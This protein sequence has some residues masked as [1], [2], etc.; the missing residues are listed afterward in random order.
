MYPTSIDGK[1]LAGGFRML[2]QTVRV[3]R[4]G[5]SRSDR[6]FEEA[7]RPCRLFAHMLTPEFQVRHRWSPN[8]VAFWDNRSTLHYAAHDF[9]QAH[10][11]MHRVT[12]KGDV[13]LGPDQL[14]GT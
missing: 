10:R 1:P 6:E 3:F 12:L 5:F 14:K 13:P 7:L 11:L 2:P 8:A 4:T 9:G